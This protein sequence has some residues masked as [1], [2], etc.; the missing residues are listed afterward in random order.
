MK[1]TISIARYFLATAC[2]T[3][4]A[5]V[6]QANE[7][8]FWKSV[9]SR[10]DPAEYRIYLE[11]YPKGKYVGEA[12][13]RLGDAGKEGRKNNLAP[14][15]VFKDCATCPDMVVIP[16]GSFDMGSDL[17][18][19]QEKPVHPVRIGLAFALAKTEVTQ[20]QWRDVMGGDRINLRFV[21]CN[22][23][24]VENVSWHDAQA[25]VQNL[26]RKTGMR[27]R[28]PSEAE[29]EY[30]CRAGGSQTYC[31]SDNVDS[32]AWYAGNSDGKTR[33]VAGKQ[34]NA[35]G[36]Y[37]MSGNVWEWTDDPKNLSWL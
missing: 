18:E 19:S 20:K 15:T 26:S 9:V 29:W 16:A 14:G 32:V 12:R 2:L 23:C 6:A 10:N 22:N 35:W 1:T 24:P 36:L 21:G 27:Y 28:L 25:Y 8:I 4:L 11:Q 5:G 34:A 3:L 33:P 31:G 17:G 13:R 30:A 37:D 7:E